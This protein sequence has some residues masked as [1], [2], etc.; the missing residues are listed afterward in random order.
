[1]K[2][3]EEEGEYEKKLISCLGQINQEWLLLGKVI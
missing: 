2:S 3:G 1:M